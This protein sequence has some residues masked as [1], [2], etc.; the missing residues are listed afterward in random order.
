MQRLLHSLGEHEESVLDKYLSTHPPEE[1]RISEIKAVTSEK[2]LLERR[3]VQGDG[4]YAERWQRRLAQLRRINQTY[5]QYDRGE[6]LLAKNEY[7]KALQVAD[8]AIGVARDQ[9]PFH[10]LKGD[11]LL[12]LNRLSDARAAFERTLDVDRRYVPANVGLG[13]VAAGRRDYAEA[14]RQFAV[15]AR[16]FPASVTAHYGLGLARYNQQKYKEAISPLEAAAGALPKH[17]LAHYVL[18]VC[19]DRTGQQRGAYDEYRHALSV[20]LG[21]EE[22]GQALQRVTVLEPSVAGARQ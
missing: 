13:W 4:V 19:Y 21:G 9:A 12:G 1:N 15:A 11:A 16:G 20:G 10:R 2:R 6:S 14:E 8:E 18:G 3:Y 22:R 17:P 7:D 5:Q